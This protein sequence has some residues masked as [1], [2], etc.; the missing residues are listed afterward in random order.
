MLK[1]RRKEYPGG[2]SIVKCMASARHSKSIEHSMESGNA[3]TVHSRLNIHEFHGESESHATTPN[4]RKSSGLLAM[5][6]SINVAFI[7]L[8]Y[9]HPSLNRNK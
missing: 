5:V 3:G 4:A 2:G 8:I 6:L 1:S 9:M 7:Y